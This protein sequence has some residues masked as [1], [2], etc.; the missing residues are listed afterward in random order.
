MCGIAGAA[1]SAAAVP[2]D[3]NVLARMTTAIAH[4]GPDD[5]G[6]YHSAIAPDRAARDSRELKALGP[7]ADSRP[8]AALGHRRLSI[9]DL[10]GGHQ[11]LANEDGT[12]WI[13]F[14][15][16]IYNYRELQGPLERQGHRFRTSSDTETIVHLYEQYGTDCVKYLR[17]MFAF[18][19][20]DQ[21]RRQLFLARD[22]LG[23]KPLVYRHD[24][25]RL[26]FA[27]ELKALLQV[28]GIS[29]ELDHRAVDAYL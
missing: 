27:S 12:I 1:W 21:N 29:R 17:G 25:Q 4:R 15:G 22:R 24:S 6:Y 7:P 3:I 13:T 26:L 2:L 5:A 14:N 20:W 16:E 11:P 28:P 18:A 8:G 10:S 9:I 23:K 19:I